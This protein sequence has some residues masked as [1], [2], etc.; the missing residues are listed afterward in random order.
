MDGNSSEQDSASGGGTT[1]KKSGSPF[2]GL[3]R[4]DLIKKCRGLLGIAQ[5]AKQAKDE[6][7]EENRRLKE[8]LSQ[9]ETQKTADKDCMKAMQ[10]MVASLTEQKLNA[11]MKV[12]ELDKL[13]A[14]LRREVDGCALLKGQLDKLSIENEGFQRQI[15]RLTEENEELLADLSGMETKVKEMEV[16][17]EKAEESKLLLEQE[18]LRAKNETA[19]SGKEEKLIRKLKLYKNKVQ[20]ISAKILLL[21]SD[22]KI[23]IK[24]V[25]EYSEQ[26]PKWQKE[27]LNASDMLFSRIQVL[28]KENAFLKKENEDILKQLQ[29]YDQKSVQNDDL[30]EKIKQVV[31]ENEVLESKIVDKQ[32]V[33]DEIESNNRN[34]HSVIGQIEEKCQMKET[35]IQSIQLENQNLSEKF[36]LLSAKSV[37]EASVLQTQHDDIQDRF[38]RQTRELEAKINQLSEVEQR[39]LSSESHDGRF[40]KDDQLKQA[41]NELQESIVNLEELQE[42]YNVLTAENQQLLKTNDE[43]SNESLSIQLERTNLKERLQDAEI[44]SRELQ[45]TIDQLKAESLKLD[46]DHQK[47][48]NDLQ[49]LSVQHNT[50]TKV[51]TN[52][53]CELQS[54]LAD[55]DQ[56][57]QQFQQKLEDTTSI[58][59]SLQGQYDIVSVQNQQLRE[60]SDTLVSEQSAHQ[61]ELQIL[62]DALKTEKE[63]L[64]KRLFEV[65]ESAKLLSQQ[66]EPLQDSLSNA[67]DQLSTKAEQL[68]QFDKKLREEAEQ[69]EKRQDELSELQNA[70]I[71]KDN[72]VQQLQQK[73]RDSTSALEG[74]Q[75]QYNL[76]TKQNQQLQTDNESLSVNNADNRSDLQTVQSKL[77]LVKLENSDLLS[78]LKEIN[79]I[80]KERGGVISLQ[81]SKI[82]ELES[83]KSVLQQKVNELDSPHVNQ[84]RQ[85]THDLERQLADKEAELA[86]LKDRDRSFDAQ[87]DVMST[88]TISRADESARLREIDDSFEEKYNKLRSL[89]VK[90]KKKVAEQTLQLQ[91]FEKDRETQPSGKN[92][93]S[94]QAEYDKVLDQLEVERQNVLHLETELKDVKDRLEKQNQEIET[95]NQVRTEL[96]SSSKKDKSS[97]ESTI[98]EYREQLQNLK[99]E[100]EAFNLAKKEIDSE[101][102]KLKA[103]L[104]AKEKQLNEEIESQKA[105]KAEVEK[106]RLAAKKAN[107]LNLEMEAYEKSLAE[108]NK[109]LEMKKVHEKE[110]EGNIEALEGTTKSLKSQLTLLEQSLNAERNHSQELKKNVDLQQE[111]LRVSEHQRGETNVELAQLKVDYERIKLEIESNRLELNDAVTEK[112]KANSLME[113]EKSKL[114]KQVYSMERDAEELKS[115][116]EEKAQEVEDVRTEF[117]SYKI[118]AQSVL[119]QNQNKDGGRE[120]ELEEE[121]QN[122]TKTLELSQSK[123]QSVTQQISELGRSCEELREDKTRLQNRCKELHDLVEESRLQNE[124]LMEECRHTNLNHQEALKTQRLQNETLINCYKKQ[125]E[126]LQEQHSKEIEGLQRRVTQAT[127]Q[128]SSEGSNDFRNN[129]PYIPSTSSGM[130]FFR[131]QHISDEQKINLLLMEREEGEGSESTSSQQN[132]SSIPK[133]KTSISSQQNQRARS[134]RDLIPLDELLNSSF[135]DASV[136]EADSADLSGR[137]SVSPTIELQHTKESLTKQESRVRHLTALLA[138]AEQDLA[139]LTQL[140]ELLKEELRRNE[141]SIEREKHVHNSEY[142][143]NV[144]FKFLTLNSGDEKSHLVPV[145]NTILRLSPE[146]TQKLNN[147]ARGTDG[148]GRGWTGLL[149]N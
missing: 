93:Q 46:S 103:T 99:R 17:M 51:E 126:D 122:L 125:I 48:L 3:N 87:S 73:L 107:V 145:L 119:R 15:K 139:K 100:K 74:F 146:E 76:L 132:P 89:A 66:I 36:N 69:N 147:V 91:K 140:N 98:R 141:R 90:L 120:R 49:E 123:L 115:R 84:L 7:L 4:E 97:L 92:L 116:L 94:L 131:G 40:D 96:D 117:A 149:W 130:S 35:E 72:T 54:L 124:S 67:H 13:V 64:Q 142:L 53:V 102:Q 110:L 57:L 109:K 75:E 101:N 113:S 28:E 144:I 37:Q 18:L 143:K 2:D 127:L 20:E 112:D 24:T 58:L 71:E 25:R 41:Q 138:E 62:N 29:I 95:L 19:L 32:K 79:E 105:L 34:L 104:K 21:K 50:K 47:T 114:M 85:Q 80:L 134:N 30:E 128:H 27:L 68:S 42:K 11:A 9:A 65:E 6:C 38:M 106:C 111:K 83:E 70:I 26:V 86:A 148:S 118:R 44:N 135:D 63:V 55:R 60:A 16:G 45:E 88:S 10:E 23:L 78:E 56:Q 137:P 33:I 52:K 82:S 12:D 77:E 81:L 129:N 108:L 39:L 1:A 31:A 59:E 14:G 43:L 133:R 61:A 8:Q 5:K 22:R 136:F 121:V